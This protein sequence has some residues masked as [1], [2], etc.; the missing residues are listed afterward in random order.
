M[1]LIEFTRPITVHL[2]RSRTGCV[3]IPAIDD[4]RELIMIMSTATN[5]DES[6]AIKMHKIYGIN[7]FLQCLHFDIHSVQEFHESDSVL[8]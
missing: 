1:E 4:R 2:P 3:Q 5:S 6:D 7:L 8:K